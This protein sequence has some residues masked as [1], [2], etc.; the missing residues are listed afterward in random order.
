MKLIKTV[1]ASG[2]PVRN[3]EDY[4]EKYRAMY[5]KI[6]QDLN[7]SAS[8]FLSKEESDKANEV[9]AAAEK[10][11]Q[12]EY[13]LEEQWPMLVTKKAWKDAVEKFGPITVVYDKDQKA[14]SYVILDVPVGA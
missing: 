3:V 12:K 7:I 11:L 9:L 10:E 8:K 2:M 4:S 1:R 13:P 6:L 5:D 14:L